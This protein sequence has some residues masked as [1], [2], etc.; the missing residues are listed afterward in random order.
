MKLDFNFTLQAKM[1]LKTNFKTLLDN[2]EKYL[3]VPI[4]IRGGFYFCASKD[5]RNKRDLFLYQLKK[6][7]KNLQWAKDKAIQKRGNLDTKEE[8]G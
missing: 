4:L 5:S 3:F 1:H 2:I 6:V 8:K 7:K